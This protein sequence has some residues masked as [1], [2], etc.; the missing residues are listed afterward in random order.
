MKKII[1]AIVMV[2]LVMCVAAVKAQGQSVFEWTQ[3]LGGDGASILTT[4]ITT[5]NQSATTT[6]GVFT[7]YTFLFTLS[8]GNLNGERQNISPFGPGASTSYY[9]GPLVV[10]Q[11]GKIVNFSTWLNPSAQSGSAESIFNILVNGISI[12]ETVTA[13]F[14]HQL[15]EYQYESV[16]PITSIQFDYSLSAVATSGETGI[17]VSMP[18]VVNSVPEPSTYA[19][20]VMSS[21]LGLL[22]ARRKKR[23]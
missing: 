23:H 4:P 7:S 17:S 12:P 22:F 15:V 13:D 11:G 2:S 9:I 18:S 10:E 20:I 1:L 16:N 5:N 21:S 14:S 3:D 6:L 8:G 19:L